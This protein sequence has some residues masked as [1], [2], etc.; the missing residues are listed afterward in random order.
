[1]ADDLPWMSVKGLANQ[2]GHSGE[3]HAVDGKDLVL[4]LHAGAARF[5]E[6]LHQK[7]GA[8]GVLERRPGA[9]GIEEAVKDRRGAGDVKERRTNSQDGQQQVRKF[10]EVGLHGP[11]RASLLLL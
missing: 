5:G 9:V 10:G 1:M 7:A 3:R 6:R 11:N 2:P 4:R 8:V